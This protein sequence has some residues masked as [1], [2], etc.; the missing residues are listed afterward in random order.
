[1]TSRS[2][3]WGKQIGRKKTRPSELIRALLKKGLS[4][5]TVAAALNT[6]H[7][8]C[9]L[10][11]SLMKKE[12]AEEKRR[13]AEEQKSLPD[14]STITAPNVPAESAVAI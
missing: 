2:S 5:R 14:F 4:L 8:S 3:I 11:R 6:S 1:L 9:S 7:G 10:E 12:E 13:L